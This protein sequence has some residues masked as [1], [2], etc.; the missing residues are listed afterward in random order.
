MLQ[1]LS[2]TKSELK[3]L[4]GEHYGGVTG[5]LQGTMRK[6][7]PSQAQPVAGTSSNAAEPPAKR[8]KVVVDPTT[9]IDLT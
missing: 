5:V 1:S 3:V 9:I 4:L 7:D 8:R 2:R 6:Y